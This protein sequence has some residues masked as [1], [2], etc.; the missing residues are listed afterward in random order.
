M[1]LRKQGRRV[2]LSGQPPGAVPFRMEGFWARLLLARLV[3]RVVF[4]HLLTIRTPLG[5][6]ARAKMLHKATPLIRVR[7]RDLDAAGIETVPRTVGARDGRPVLADGAV[8]EVKNVVW[9]TGFE[10]GFSF[11]DLPVFARDG[12]PLHEEGV[13]GSEP[14]LYFVGIHFLFSVSSTMIQGVGRDAARVVGVIAERLAQPRAV[15]QLPRLAH[16]H[17]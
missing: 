16:A 7:P 11:V 12:E 1:E 8:V 17:S 14:G 4:H 13:V 15:G 5:R 2:L 10:R 9:S 6:K 3:L